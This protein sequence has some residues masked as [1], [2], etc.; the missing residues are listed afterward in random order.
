MEDLTD[1]DLKRKSDKSHEGLDHYERKW[2]HIGVATG[3][4][5]VLKDYRTK[6]N[7]DAYL[8]I[9]GFKD[10]MKNWEFPLHF[11][12]FETS[13]VALPFYDKMQFSDGAMSEALEKALL[14][15]CVLDTLAMVFIWE[16]FFNECNK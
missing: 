1:A 13:A 9:A 14:T 11:I 3:N 12:D 4:E 15:Y 10:E 2:L 16:Y 5:E 7:G 8:D 6:M